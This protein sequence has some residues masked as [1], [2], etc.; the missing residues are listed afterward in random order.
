MFECTIYLNTRNDADTL[1]KNVLDKFKNYRI[2]PAYTEACKKNGSV[3]FRNVFLLVTLLATEKETAELR[4]LVEDFGEYLNQPL[5]MTICNLRLL[6]LSCPK[7]ISVPTQQFGSVE[8]GGELPRELIEYLKDT[9]CVCRLYRH[10][11]T[12]ATVIKFP[13]EQL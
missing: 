8:V 3:T 7:I 10:K 9:G 11:G 13:W 2:L 4:M 1:K 5:Q 6:D 12:V